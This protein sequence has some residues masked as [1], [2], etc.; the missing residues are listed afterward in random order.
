PFPLLF[1]SCFNNP[2]GFNR[3]RRALFLLLPAVHGRAL[4]GSPRLAARL[5]AAPPGQRRR[6]RGP[7]AR[8]VPAPNPQAG[9]ARLRQPRGS[10]RLL[11]RH[12]AGHVHQ[13]VAPSR[14]RT[15]VARHAGGPAAGPC[16]LGGTAGDR[17]GGPAGNRRAAARP[18]AQGGAGFPDV[19]GVRHERGR[20]GRRT[21]R[22]VAHG[23]Q[24]CRPGHA[25]L[26]AGARRADGGGAAPGG[27]ALSGPRAQ[28]DT[29]AAA[30]ARRQAGGDEAP[31]PHHVMEQAAQWYALLVSGEAS[32][33]DQA[34]WRAWL[35]AHR[36][37]RQAWQY[38]ESVS[39]RVLAPLQDTP[40]PRLMASQVYSAHARVRARRRTLAAL[41]AVAA[42]GIL[43][44]AGRPWP[45]LE[46][47]Y[48]AW[49]AGYRTG[50]GE[51]RAFTLEDGSRIWLNAASAVDADMGAGM[52]RLYLAAGEIL[53]ATRSG[54]P[55]PFIVDTPQGRMRA[56]GTRFTVRREPDRTFLAVYAGSVEIRT[57][58][59]AA[60]CVIPAG[61]QARF[62]RDAI[63]ASAPADPAREAWSRGELI[64]WDL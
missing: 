10:A 44:W 32:A 52:R 23:A 31:P 11:A 24:V 40:D 33:A 25:A 9:A 26:H 36:Q 22:I 21:G 58:A 3:E 12:G 7:G 41:G 37:H 28:P 8:G 14:D 48:I 30:A 50:T 55:R 39:Q 34:R 45:A 51:I 20:S 17:A 56:L 53:V 35:A 19:G 15:S 54:D 63:L 27:R 60:S 38:V 46:D 6:R 57:A 47:A 59:D 18:V 49:T 42:T 61:R 29:P 43:G 62:S 2:A 1:I 13:S 5:A 4:C 64:A 16:A